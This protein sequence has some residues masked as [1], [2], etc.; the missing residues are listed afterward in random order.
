MIKLI[1]SGLVI[2]STNL[3]N[4]KRNSF[5]V[6][7]ISVFA[8]C[9]GSFFL[10]GGLDGFAA[11]DAT[12]LQFS[13]EAAGLAAAGYN[14]VKMLAGNSKLLG[15][16]NSTDEAR[17]CFD[18]RFYHNS[19]FV[20]YCDLSPVTDTAVLYTKDGVSVN[21]VNQVWCEENHEHNWCKITRTSRHVVSIRDGEWC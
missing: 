3:S 8:I 9:L 19:P 21:G 10:G 6:W 5:D 16:R 12:A 7:G 11:F 13:G 18:F 15:E 17:C 4:E 1:A 2:S 20:L 14:L